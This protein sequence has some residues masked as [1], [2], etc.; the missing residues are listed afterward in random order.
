MLPAPTGTGAA[1][2]AGFWSNR[3]SSTLVASFLTPRPP[4][5]AAGFLGA[6]TFFPVRAGRAAGRAGGGTTGASAA[7][8]AA[9]AAESAGASA[10]SAGSAAGGAALAVEAA[11]LL[12][13]AF[14][15]ALPAF[16]SFPFF[17]I[18]A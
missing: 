1:G 18:Y 17:I 2:S 10:G 5:L 16:E 4:L 6:S 7:A 3:L 9:G 13:C 8:A 14:G 12:S 11:V 15:A